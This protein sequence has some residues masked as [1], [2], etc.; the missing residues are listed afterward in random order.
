MDRNTP[1]EIIDARACARARIFWVSAL[2]CVWFAF[3]YYEL[4]EPEF[5][6]C[7]MLAWLCMR[8]YWD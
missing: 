6:L 7:S 3:V 1:A 8:A 2:L 5:M 4:R